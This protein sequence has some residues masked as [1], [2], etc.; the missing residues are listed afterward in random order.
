MV[1]FDETWVVL[2]NGMILQKVV[3]QCLRCRHILPES[4]CV[5]Y[6]EP[7]WVWKTYGSCLDYQPRQAP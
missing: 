6:L 1:E 5:L 2:P 4:V 3:P 7:G